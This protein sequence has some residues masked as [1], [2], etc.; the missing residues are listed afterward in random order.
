[1]TK[2]YVSDEVFCKAIVDAAKKGEKASDVAARLNLEV[3]TVKSRANKLR[4]ANVP[5]PKLTQQRN[6]VDLV[7]LAKMVNDY[8]AEQA[9]VESTQPV[10]SAS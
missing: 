6:K 10:E 3:T 1:M 7:A 8:V 9:Q 4:K 2:M 5:L